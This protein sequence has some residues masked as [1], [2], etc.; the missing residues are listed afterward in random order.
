MKGP[1]SEH[2]DWQPERSDCRQEPGGPLMVLHCVRSAGWRTDTVTVAPN[3][4]ALRA[5]TIWRG[6]PATIDSL[7]R[8][9][10][11]LY[12]RRA[13]SFRDCTPGH[14]R[15]ELGDSIFAV[16]ARSVYFDPVRRE[17]QEITEVRYWRPFKPGGETLEWCSI[18]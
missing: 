12:S 9:R 10:V 14:R 8:E 6:S 13:E 2:I 16:L 18:S 1:L 11:A 4:T 3:A 15:L 7:W 17:N 5:I